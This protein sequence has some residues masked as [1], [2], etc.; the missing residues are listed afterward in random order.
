MNDVRELTVD[1][2]AAVNGGATNNGRGLS[3]PPSPVEVI[4]KWILNHI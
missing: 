3:P 1:E 4:I 2:L